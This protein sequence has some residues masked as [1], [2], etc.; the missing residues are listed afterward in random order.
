MNLKDSSGKVQTQK[1]IILSH[2]LEHSEVE[3]CV[4]RCLISNFGQLLLSWAIL[5]FDIYIGLNE[6]Q[7]IY[8]FLFTTKPRNG[9]L[10]CVDLH[11]LHLWILTNR[12]VLHLYSFI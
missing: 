8:S 9:M 3:K 11:D 7:L 12:S 5:V 6:R 4:R 2:I 1:H 10:H